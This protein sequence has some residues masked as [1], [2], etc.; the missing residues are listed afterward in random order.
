MKFA[1]LHRIAAVGLLTLLALPIFN[2]PR[3]TS[4]T[5]WVRDGSPPIPSTRWRVQ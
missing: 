1:K 5:D 3:R 4:K 2:W